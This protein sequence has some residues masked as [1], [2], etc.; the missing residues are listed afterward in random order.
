M[1]LQRGIEGLTTLD[2]SYVSSLS[3]YFVSLFG[4]RGLTAMALGADANCACVHVPI[5]RQ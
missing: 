1:M 5:A 3:L 4:L 2:V